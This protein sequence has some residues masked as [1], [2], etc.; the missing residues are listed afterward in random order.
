MGCVVACEFGVLCCRFGIA[1]AQ[2]FGGSQM[3]VGRM[4]Q[5]LTGA[6][7]VLLQGRVVGRL[8]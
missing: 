7:V 8:W 1:C 6:L 5:M 2:C 4:L 3:A